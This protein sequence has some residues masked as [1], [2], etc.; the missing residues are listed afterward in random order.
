MPGR[1]LVVDD[2]STNRMLLRA[3]LS[4]S[5]YDVVEACDGEQAL[6]IAAREDID[7]VLLDVMMPGIDGF[8]VCR[9][10]KNDPKTMHIPVVMVTALGDPQDRLLGL[11]AGADDFLSKPFD[12]LALF[13][14]AS[15]LIRIKMMIDE[16][17]LRD[18]TTRDLGF[19]QMMASIEG[20]GDPCTEILLVTTDD[21]TKE[22]MRATL[23]AATNCRVETCPDEASLRAM[24]A[25]NDYDAFLL[26]DRKGGTDALR[27]CAVLRT[28]PETRQATILVLIDEERRDRANVA[29]EIGAND[30][31]VRPVDPAE[32]TARMRSQLRRKRFSDR[33]RA[34]MRDSMVMAVTDHMTGVY[35]RRY[36][37]THLGSLITRCQGSGEPLAAMI[38]DLDRFK[39]V[40][41]TWGH[42]AGDMVIKEF[43]QRL[44]QNCRPADLVARMGGEEFLVVM[45]NVSAAQASEAAER[46]RR[47]VAAPAFVI[48]EDGRELAVTVSIGLAMLLPGENADA[49]IHRA[50]MALYDSK[51]EGRNRVTLDAA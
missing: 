28:Q 38:L 39:S 34:N 45:P 49:V 16:L 40:N 11:E 3:K 26:D 48:S 44:V 36:A 22:E 18:E 21:S 43:A 19:E 33:L 23:R 5:Y 12:D 17:R 50:D 9:R 41:D 51:H 8:E 15:S 24:I 13:A 25:N 14:R 2:I 30:F 20:E 29:L 47:S 6:E 10:L 27:L 37:T 32:L 4:A 42:A 1:I 7:L 35:N 31:V 46:I